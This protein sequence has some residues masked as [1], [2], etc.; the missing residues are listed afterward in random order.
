MNRM[1]GAK[2]RTGANTETKGNALIAL[3]IVPS[4]KTQTNHSPM[5]DKNSPR[6]ARP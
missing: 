2:A 5:K 1:S 6:E 4:K 3:T